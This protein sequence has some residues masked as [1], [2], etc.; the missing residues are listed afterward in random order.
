MK[1]TYFFLLLFIFPIIFCCKLN[2]QT[3]QSVLDKANELVLNGRLEEAQI[4]LERFHRANPKEVKITVAYAQVAYQNKKYGTFMDLYDEALE[5]QPKNFP[6]KLDYAKML[7]DINEYDKCLP[8]LETYLVHDPNNI[9]ALFD[10]AKILRYN[11]EYSES[12]LALSKILSKDPSNAEA[13]ENYAEVQILKSSWLKLTAAY[14]S[15]SQPIDLFAPVLEGG[16]YKNSGVQL[17]MNVG[18]LLYSRRTQSNVSNY[19]FQLE[20]R[21]FIKDV[22]VGIN[23]GFGVVKYGDNQFDFT[24]RVKFDKYAERYILLTLSGERKPYFGSLY[25]LDTNIM[26]HSAAATLSLIT[27]E[28]WNGKLTFTTDFFDGFDNPI[29]TAVSS[30][31]APRLKL[32]DFDFR[33]GYGLFFSTSK[34][35]KFFSDKSNAE[36]ISSGS[37]APYYIGNY[38]PYYTPKNQFA[39][40]LLL[41]IGYSPSVQTQAGLDLNYGFLATA[42]RAY[43][44]KVTN[45]GGESF[46]TKNYSEA[47]YNP[48]DITFFVRSLITPKIAMNIDFNYSRNFFYITRSIALGV[49]VNFF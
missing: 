12:S 21:S 40:S 16:L 48:A 49:K 34:I 22:G 4:Y 11:E 7:F 2:A 30:L 32:K 46:V 37:T 33:L 3:T 27:K 44:S 25:S 19:K 43:F 35:D 17:K 41:S 24:G 28:S 26:V 14:I 1:K 10:K 23:Y 36:I 29:T 5:F 38:Y 31:Y 13:R 9:E 45:S 15:D 20:N 39:N 18:A 8:I 6:M 47:D 42:D